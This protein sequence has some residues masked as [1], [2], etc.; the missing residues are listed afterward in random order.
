MTKIAMTGEIVSDEWSEIYDFFGIKNVSPGKVRKAL[1]DAEGKDVVLEVNSPGGDVNAGSEIYYVINEYTGKTRADITGFAGS[2]ATFAIMS[3]D[4]IRMTP[5]A[6][7]MIHDT[8]ISAFG[9]A[10]DLRKHAGLLETADNG[11][12]D[13][14]VEKTGLDKDFILELMH[15][16]TWMNAADAL[17]YGFVDEVISPERLVDGYG[18]IDE[19]ERED[20][21]NRYFA[22]KAKNKAK[23][24]LKLL[25]LRS[26]KK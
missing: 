2:A 24:K 25:K 19:I 15:E 8:S 11:I 13:A 17:D 18:L 23:A 12:A 26:D 3:S 20:M 1:E 10:D 21:K 14:Y 5:S 9:N 6:L 4:K 22:E 7:F 16:E